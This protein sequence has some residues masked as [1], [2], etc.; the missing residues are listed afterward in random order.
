MTMRLDISIGP[1]QGFVAQS[2]RTRD[3]WGSSYLLSFLSAHAMR[4]A[5]RAGCKIV[6]P[7]VDHDPLYR[8]VSGCREGDPPR[9]GSVPNHLVVEVNGDVRKVAEAGV[10][11]LEMA[12]MRLCAAVWDKFVAHACSDGDGTEGIWDRQTCAFWEVTW[13]AGESAAGSGLLARRKHWRSHRPPDEAGDKCTMMHDWQEISGYTRSQSPASRKRQD[14][15]WKKVRARTGE[16]DLGKK[17]R[18]CAIA[19]VKRLYPKVCEEALGWPVDRIGWPSTVHIAARPWID[20]VAAA[21]PEQASDYARIVKRNAKESPLGERPTT[22]VRRAGDFSRLD[23]NYFHRGFVQSERLCPLKDDSTG[24]RGE[25]V[26]ELKAIYDAK[27]KNDR[28]IGPPLSFYAL[29]LADDGDRLGKLLGE[30]GEE[31][32][33]TVGLA[34]RAFTSKVPQIVEAHDGVTVYAGGDDVLAML[35]VP[36]ALS[37][38]DRLSREY[39]QAFGGRSNATLS[40]AVVFAHVRLPLQA[41]MGEAHRLLDDVAKDGNGRNSLAAAVLKPGGLNCQ[42][43]TSWTRKTP[44]GESTPAVVLLDKLT[45][46]LDSNSAEPSLSSALVYRIRETLINLCGWEGWQPGSWGRLQEDLDIRAFLRAEIGHSLA[47][48]MGEGYESRADE[49]VDLAHSVLGP[50]RNCKPVDSAKAS[51]SSANA[52]A[53]RRVPD[54]GHHAE[55]GFDALLLARFLADPEEDRGGP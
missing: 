7:V 55:A 40:A 14:R 17:E 51:A 1:V 24:T 12:W 39:R 21:I 49:L 2:R 3:L 37:C 47:A 30:L 20:R 13:T 31:G 19:L 18:L 6:Q 52:R 27:D 34:L 8:W 28:K 35:P 25:I 53:R 38:A 22:Q 5:K 43:T 11:A 23:A 33:Q 45:K 48:R 36:H 10:Q 29:L 54:Q 44:S 26:D 16:L 4:G 50:A 9:I 41:A 46:S 15:F 42:W 32:R